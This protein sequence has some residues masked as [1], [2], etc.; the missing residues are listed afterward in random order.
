MDII[1]RSRSILLGVHDGCYYASI[2]K[3]FLLVIIWFVFDR[4]VAKPEVLVLANY[5][6]A[7]TFFSIYFIWKP[8][9]IRFLRG[10]LRGEEYK[11]KKD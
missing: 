11:N 4:Y 8:K 7:F 3:S 2:I 6:I 10:S 1:D 9:L 5:F